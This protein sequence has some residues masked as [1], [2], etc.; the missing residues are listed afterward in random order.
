MR[1]SAKYIWIIIV[2]LFVGGFLLAQTSGLLGTAPVTSTTSVATVN[3]EDILATTWYNA[4]QNLEQQQT[5]QSGRSV[6]LDE[7]DRIADQAFEQLV[8]DALLRQEYKRRGIIVTDEEI[9]TAAQ[10]N[11]PPQLMQSPDLQTEGRFDP[12][13]YRR[14]LTSSVARQEGLLVQLEQYYRNE[15]PKEKLFDQ[16][17]ADVYIPDT[18]LW[19]RYKDSHDSAQL[20][21]AV[22]TPDRVP[23]SAVSVSDDEIRAYYDAHKKDFD[24]TGRAQLSIVSIPRS[25]T[26]ADSAGVR[27]R[28]AALRARILA[29]EKFEDVARA[30]SADSGSAAN[31]GS[32]G[33]GVRGRFVKPFEDAAYA[34]K[35]G[36]IS[37]P[38]LTQFGYHIIKL[39]VRKGDT[40]SL[41]H[42]LLKIDQSDAE[43]TATD[44][45]ADSLSRMAASTD[46]PQ[47][48]DEAA[49][50][51]RLPIVRATAT[52]GSPLTINGKLI[53]SVGPWAFKGV[54][55][56]EISELFDADEGY[57]MARLDS[58]EP[59]GTRSLDQAKSEIRLRLMKEKKLT[60]LG[61]AA[62]NFAKLGAAGSLEDAARLTNMPLQHTG[63]FTRVTGDPNLGGLP[64]AIGA[65]FALPVRAVSDPIRSVGAVVVE[66]VDQRALA[67]SAAWEAQKVVQR[68][69]E[70]NTLRQ[71][72][73]RL[74]LDNLRQ[75]AKITDRRK[76][77]EAAARRTAQ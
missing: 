10:N 58:I 71:Q 64:E 51:L 37:E 40:L 48:L 13:K 62:H 30:E 23:D 29:G 34:L 28:A 50:L 69:S 21:F 36:E 39:D 2:I 63:M 14:F 56:G 38:V 45:K 26:A 12:D 25:V 17:A 47:K 75:T 6:T 55:P 22:F 19:E 60:A 1:A 59:S 42:I 44:R 24:R 32:L 54:K 68:Q 52:E 72:R 3:G 4:T 5:Q 43:A 74:F 16:V 7:R 65:A 57:F 8:T 73:V 77:I 70:I 67:D 11:P 15:I 27:A 53:P 76:Q 33:P 9:T 66:R 35:P 49:R 61:P 46:Q 18:H 20:T 41:R 31:G